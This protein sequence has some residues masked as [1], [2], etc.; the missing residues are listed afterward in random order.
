[1]GVPSRRVSVALVCLVCLGV[2]GVTVGA[3]WLSRDGGDGGDRL[4]RAQPPQVTG[5]LEVSPGR[6]RQ[7]DP[8]TVTLTDGHVVTGEFSLA[9]WDGVGWTYQY[10]LFGSGEPF[11]EGAQPWRTWRERTDSVPDQ[12]LGGP[13]PV[14]LVI[15]SRIIAG[16]YRLCVEPSEPPDPICSGLVVLD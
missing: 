6:L 14:H 16:D 1:M 12:I 7:G 10:Q 3:L 9:V 4:D 8:F 11:E 13:D 2:A 5:P 15:P